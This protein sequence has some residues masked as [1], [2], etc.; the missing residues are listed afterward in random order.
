MIAALALIALPG[1]TETR[2]RARKAR[3]LGNLRNLASASHAYASEDSR[4]LLI[5]IHQMTV[6]TLHTQGWVGPLTGMGGGSYPPGQGAIRIGWGYSYGGR[7]AIAPFGPT[8]VMT[9]PNGYWGARTRPLNPYVVGS[10][11]DATIEDSQSF[12]C[13][14]D[15]GYALHPVSQDAPREIANVP[16]Y[17]VAGNSY[18]ASS[19]GYFWS[20]AGG[21][22][23]GI[24][25]VSVFG[26]SRSSL[27]QTDRLMLF[28]E[29]MAYSLSRFLGG[30]SAD[31]AP[32]WHG[33][34]WSDQAALADGSA[35]MLFLQQYTSWTPATLTEMN[36]ATDSPW[37][38]Y[39]RKN[40]TWTVDTYPTPG[41]R[42][43]MRN[44]AGESVT[45]SVPFSQL[46]R[47]PYQNHNVIDR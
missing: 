18:R 6:S 27:Q 5:P 7:T 36:V 3:C 30:G 42:I 24:F 21:G 39:L 28:V 15:T 47:W 13:P 20:G 8:T 2:E 44:P 29:P 19:G 14:A 10:T 43:V 9:D 4:E 32:T 40:S 41:T 26:K 31:P 11:H 34:Y 17:D 37:Y 16:C 33:E 1:L 46:S 12:A 25:S 45:P 22:A 38:F 35:R 23:S